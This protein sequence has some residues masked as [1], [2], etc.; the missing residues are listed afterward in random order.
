MRGSLVGRLVPG[1]DSGWK[2][3]ILPVAREPGRTRLKRAAMHQR[4]QGGNARGT[5]YRETRS[6][7]A[8]KRNEV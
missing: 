2:N 6:K 7:L 4:E 1:S 3:E 5:G 8:H